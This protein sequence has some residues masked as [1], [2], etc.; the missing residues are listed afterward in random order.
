VG[1]WIVWAVGNYWVY[2]GSIV[3]FFI[4]FFTL[5]AKTGFLKTALLT[6]GGVAVLLA[7]GYF[8]NLEFPQG[9]F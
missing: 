8:L 9:V 6:A 5:K 7:F 1:G 4:C 3:L 2:S